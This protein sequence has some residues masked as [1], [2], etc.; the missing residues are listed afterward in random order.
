MLMRGGCGRIVDKRKSTPNQ[1]SS[2]FFRGPV[3]TLCIIEPGKKEV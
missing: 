3:A 2:K 1:C